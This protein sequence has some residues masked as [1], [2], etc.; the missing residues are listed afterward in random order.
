MPPT[1]APSHTRSSLTVAAALL[2]GASPGHTREVTH[3]AFDFPAAPALQ[4]SP[5]GSLADPDLTEAST[6]ARSLRFPGT[7]WTHNDSG[8]GPRLF[9]IGPDGRRLSPPGGLTVPGATNV[10]WEAATCLPD[11]RIVVGDIG[12]NSS[13]RRNLAVWVLPEPDPRG[14]RQPAQASRTGFTYPDQLAWPPEPPTFDA[15]A[16]FWDEGALHLVTKRTDGRAALYRF[17]SLP[18]GGQ[19]VLERIA[20]IDTPTPV[21]DAALSPDGS[22]LALLGKGSITVFRRPSRGSPHVLGE[23]RWRPLD[24]GQ[25]EGIAFLSND[26]L[27]VGNEQRNLFVIPLSDLRPLGTARIGVWTGDATAPAGTAETAPPPA[28]ADGPRLLLNEANCVR[29]GRWLATDDATAPAHARDARLGRVPG[30][31]GNWLEFVVFGSTSTPSAPVDLRGWSIDWRQTGSSG[32]LRFASGPD[33]SAPA[34][35]PAGSLLTLAVEQ[36]LTD[37]AGNPVVQGSR[38]PVKDTLS[39]PFVWVHAWTGDPAWVADG[40]RFSDGVATNDNFQVR[41]RDA[42]GRIVSDWTGEGVQPSGGVNSREVFQ[43]RAR[44]TRTVPPDSPDYADSESSTL[45]A[46]NAWPTP[47]GPARQPAP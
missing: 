45:G 25:T 35:V 37:D 34:T 26:R 3:V 43:L 24:A 19:V 20:V 46:P 14:R 5:A 33:T 16:L 4:P 32:S 22:R 10:D 27:L 23:A 39:S 12:N 29:T 28:P 31:G 40:G 42:Q 21:T 6:L 41:V 15:E 8:D 30:N 18:P 11:G 44:P 13:Q 1:P 38:G 7:F 17:P 36:V 9:A 2:L 47:S